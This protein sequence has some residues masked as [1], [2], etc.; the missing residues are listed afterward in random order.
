M[1]LKYSAHLIVTYVINNLCFRL[2]LIRDSFSSLKFIKVVI[3][4]NV[5]L[6][7]SSVVSSRSASERC[8]RV[9]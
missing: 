7:V 5:T 6:A 2:S 1:F 4:A 8:E 9:V 3:K